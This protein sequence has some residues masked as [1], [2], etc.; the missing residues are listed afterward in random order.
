MAQRG[1]GRDDSV[2]PRGIRTQR[3]PAFD[4]DD[5]GET[6]DRIDAARERDS[7]W[8]DARDQLDRRI[9]PDDPAVPQLVRRRTH[10]D[11]VYE[12]ALSVEIGQKVEGRLDFPRRSH[13][14]IWVADSRLFGFRDPPEDR[15]ARAMEADGALRTHQLRDALRERRASEPEGFADRVAALADR[16]D[17]RDVGGLTVEAAIAVGRVRYGPPLDVVFAAS[18]T[19][20][21]LL[22]GAAAVLR[23]SGLAETVAKQLDRA[24]ETVAL[25]HVDLCVRDPYRAASVE[26]R[27]DA[28]RA[29]LD[30]EGIDSG[31]ANFTEWFGRTRYVAQA[32]YAVGL[33]PLVQPLPRAAVEGV[34]VRSGS[35]DRAVEFLGASVRPG[36]AHATARAVH[37]GFGAIRRLDG[38]LVD[39][40]ATARV[41]GPVLERAGLS[42]PPPGRDAVRRRFELSAPAGSARPEGPVVDD[43]PSAASLFREGR[44]PFE[45]AR[46][47][48]DRVEAFPAPAAQALAIQAWRLESGSTSVCFMDEAAAIHAGGTV[49]PG[50]RG[51]RVPGRRDADSRAVFP[52]E[53][54]GLPTVLPDAGVDQVDRI[55]AALGVDVQ[56]HRSSTAAYDAAADRVSVPADLSPGAEYVSTVA[57]AAARASGHATREGRRD[58]AAPRGSLGWV[59]EQIRTDL[60]AAKLA[61]ALGVPYQPCG[62]PPLPREAA[63]VFRRHAS[64]LCR[65]ADRVASFLIGRARGVDLPPDY[66]SHWAPADRVGAPAPSRTGE[67]RE[68]APVR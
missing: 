48:V 16:R 46:W 68:L 61:G 29:D 13:P 41:M 32:H 22:S 5:R 64:G 33:D 27:W 57:L 60:A 40:A 2:G 26:R 24:A 54:A 10:G 58:A 56:L 8:L 6:T 23:E 42:W 25:R 59:R 65:D 63:E 39:E 49:E 3:Y 19:D 44:R 14:S 4:R 36:A 34:L 45:G 18:A 37:A 21:V 35:L 43:P 20:P 11:L 53:A 12:V 31:G 55:V 47:P 28:D 67:G 66:R 62:E 1:G 9:H 50:A 51:V 30:L 38:W 52:V 17:L 15:R 7:D